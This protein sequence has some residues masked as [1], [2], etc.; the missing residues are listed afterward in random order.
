MIHLKV[1]GHIRSV[2]FVLQVKF[3]YEQI[4]VYIFK[5]HRIQCIVS[6]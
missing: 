2:Q 6:F 5:K 4:Y 1:K 3:L